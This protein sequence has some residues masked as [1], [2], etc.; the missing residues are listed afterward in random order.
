MVCT[1]SKRLFPL[2]FHRFRWHTC[3]RVTHALRLPEP[4]Q[5]HQDGGA[6]THPVRLLW[7]KDNNE[8]FDTSMIL[9]GVNPLSLSEPVCK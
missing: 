5:H 1:P 6:Q 9:E 2:G 3:L 7:D 8:I 4:R